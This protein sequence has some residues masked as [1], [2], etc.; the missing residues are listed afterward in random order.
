[1]EQ[2]IAQESAHQLGGE[3]VGLLG[4]VQGNELDERPAASYFPATLREGAAARGSGDRTGAGTG[5]SGSE[6]M[7][8]GRS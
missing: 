8:A 2:L 1:M 5:R 6:T 3:Q 4:L 7:P